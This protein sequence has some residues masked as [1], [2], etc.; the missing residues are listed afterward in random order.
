MHMKSTSTRFSEHRK[1]S[2]F[3]LLEVM[4]ALAILGVAVVAVFQ[5]FSVA[6]RATRRADDYTKA[7]FY[8]RSVLDEAY[9]VPVVED[10]SESV[11]F[12]DGFEAKTVTTLK[13][14]SEDGKVKLYEIAVTVTWPPTNSLTIRGLRNFYETES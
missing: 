11:D 6:L 2:G 5:L 10:G 1:S 4:V 13:S 7:I 3:S 14:S 9:A 12:R 8:A